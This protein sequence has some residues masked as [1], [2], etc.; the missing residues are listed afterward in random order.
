MTFSN[1]FANSF[2]IYSSSIATGYVYT[3]YSICD[4]YAKLDI[5]TVWIIYVRIIILSRKSRPMLWSCLHEWTYSSFA[6]F[7]SFDKQP[8]NDSYIWAFFE[9]RKRL[10]LVTNLVYL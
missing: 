7:F 3:I 2:N 6:D 5:G 10:V 4:Y 8:E 9:S 1:L